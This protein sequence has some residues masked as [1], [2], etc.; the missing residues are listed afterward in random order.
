MSR[1]VL[2][3]GGTGALGRAVVQRFAGQGDE[4][5]VP[6][7]VEGEVENLKALLGPAMSRVTLHRADVTAEGDVGAL[8]GA[9]EAS[10]RHVE[11]LANIVGG[12]AYASLE[13]TT[14]DLWQRMMKLNAAGTFLCARRAVARMKA[15]R[16]GRIIN[17]SSGPALNRGAA[18]M[19][20]YA[21]AKAAVLNFT[22]SLAKELVGFGIT[23]N[24]LVPSVIDTPANRLSEPGADTSRWL[25]PEDIA[26]VIGF[27][28]SNDA[29]I[30]T[31][32]AVNLTLG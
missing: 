8:F 3:T 11:I 25:R 7:I 20:A 30:L 2:V 21:A 17:V 28:A 32:T 26:A 29:G 6:W 14:P 4:V 12:F 15:A 23:A 9:I 10:G 1:T 27:L 18:N 22:E 19:S 5:H 13:E 24:A 31:G 16:F